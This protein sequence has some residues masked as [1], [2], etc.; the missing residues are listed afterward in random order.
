METWSVRFAP[1][2]TRV[3]AGGAYGNVQVF[4]LQGQRSGTAR[5]GALAYNVGSVVLPI[6]AGVTGAAAMWMRRRPDAGPDSGPSRALALTPDGRRVATGLGAKVLLRATEEEDARPTKFAVDRHDVT[7]LAFCRNDLL[8]A[9]SHHTVGLWSLDRPTRLR[10]L[11]HEDAVYALAVTRDATRL[12]TAGHSYIRVWDVDTGEPKLS[13][14]HHPMVFAADFSPDGTRLVTG[15][16][17]HSARVWDTTTGACLTRLEL[18]DRVRGVAYGPD[19]DTLA[20]A[21]G[22]TVTLL[23]LATR[24]TV[25]EVDGDFGDVSLL[26]IALSPDG[27]HLATV[28][29]GMAWLIPVPKKAP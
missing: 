20:I 22:H 14:D 24:R 28:G 10:T 11:D 15:A 7:A 26:Q 27:S 8:A 23:N 18:P 9:A 12:A 4:D 2:G 25:L 17:D 29:G 3:V 5:G 19:G 13:I 1:D 6:M 21:A 16:L